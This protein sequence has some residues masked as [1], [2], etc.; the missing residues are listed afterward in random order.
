LEAQC[1]I[2]FK[3]TSFAV[4]TGALPTRWCRLARSSSAARRI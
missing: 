4:S 3:C 1:L 2:E